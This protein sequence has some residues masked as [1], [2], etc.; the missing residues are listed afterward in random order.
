VAAALWQ[1]PDPS[2]CASAPLA[3]FPGLEPAAITHQKP[4][5]M[6]D[7]RLRHL[8]VIRERAALGK[9]FER[10]DT[11]PASS[12]QASPGVPPCP[13]PSSSP[14]QLAGGR[15]MSPLA[16]TL[17][18]G[19]REALRPAL[20]PPRPLPPPSPSPS[21]HLVRPGSA[22]DAGPATGDPAGVAVPGRP[23]QHL[24]AAMPSASPPPV[25]PHPASPAPAAAA[26][27]AARRASPTLAP[28][29]YCPT[30]AALTLLL[31]AG[32]QS[33]W[34]GSVTPAT[35]A[36]ARLRGVRKRAAKMARRLQAAGCVQAHRGG[37]WAPLALPKSQPVCKAPIAPTPQQHPSN[38]P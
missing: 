2:R 8:E 38:R 6:L 26:A 7:R 10:R 16:T 3:P 30:D 9:D 28:P 27:A 19:V 17:D 31:S 25:P 15:A 12:P 35:S 13:G 1:L 22:K 11:F 32:A 4:R 18:A 24:L 37:V 36:R 5:F 34:P 33:R 23:P 29:A 14:D 20:L 21:P